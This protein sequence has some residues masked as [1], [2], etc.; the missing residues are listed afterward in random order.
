MQEDVFLQVSFG[1]KNWLGI[2][3]LAAKDAGELLLLLFGLL[4]LVQQGGLGEDGWF[5]KQK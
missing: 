2:S 3:Q 4:T 5:Q 1:G